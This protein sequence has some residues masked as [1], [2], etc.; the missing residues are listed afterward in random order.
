[1]AS[2]EL[3]KFTTS[4]YVSTLRLVPICLEIIAATLV[5]FQF[6]SELFVDNFNFKNSG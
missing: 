1:M 6:K 5:Y 4:N 3:S 2:R